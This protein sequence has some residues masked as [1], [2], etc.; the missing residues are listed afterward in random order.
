MFGALLL[1]SR[2]SLRA[3]NSCSLTI[4][5]AS[6]LPAASRQRQVADEKQLTAKNAEPLNLGTMSL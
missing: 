3:L 5:K 4:E 6:V 1:T 2:Y